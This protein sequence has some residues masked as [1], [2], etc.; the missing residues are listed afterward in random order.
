[1][2]R[3][4]AVCRTRSLDFLYVTAG[5]RLHQIDTRTG[6]DLRSAPLSSQPFA[7]I[8][9]HEGKGCA[10]TL[11]GA[12]LFRIY[13]AR[14][15]KLLRKISIG[16]RPPASSLAIAPVVTAVENQNAVFLLSG[17]TRQ[18]VTT[19]DAASGAARR[20][21]RLQTPAVVDVA[22]DAKTRHAFIVS[23]GVP[24][25]P[26]TNGEGTAIDMK[27]GKLLRSVQP[28]AMAAYSEVDSLTGHLFVL[29]RPPL[30][31]QGTVDFWSARV[32]MIDTRAGA[33]VRETTIPETVIAASRVPVDSG[34]HRV[35]LTWATSTST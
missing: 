3:S 29:S 8:A 19:L 17:P 15:L 5:S 11:D 10:F 4:R 31:K 20:K 26:A 23:L 16:N 14:T 12:G 35:Y 30:S 6:R 13:D 28:G 21:I 18:V 7:S 27:T 24:S 2:T 22:L 33:L 9:V 34:N 25:P 1:M 32:T